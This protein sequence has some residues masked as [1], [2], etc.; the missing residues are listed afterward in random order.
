MKSLIIR[1][2]LMQRGYSTTIG[3]K[4]AIPGNY[5]IDNK[6]VLIRRVINI[7]DNIPDV[8]VLMR[9]IPLRFEEIEAEIDWELT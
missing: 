4:R 5:Q 6:T 2:L 8:S 9:V 7:P 1:Q 3:K